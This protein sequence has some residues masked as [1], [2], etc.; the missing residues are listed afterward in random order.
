MVRPPE[1]ILPVWHGC[2]LHLANLIGGATTLWSV[3]VAASFDLARRVMQPGLLL[4]PHTEPGISPIRLADA[5][6]RG[7]S[8]DVLGRYEGERGSVAIGPGMRFAPLDHFVVGLH[9]P[10]PLEGWRRLEE[11]RAAELEKARTAARLHLLLQKWLTTTPWALLLPTVNDALVDRFRLDPDLDDLAVALR[12]LELVHPHPGRPA[13]GPSLQL[14]DGFLR[15][16]RR[17][18]EMLGGVGIEA[19]MDRLLPKKRPSQRGIE[20][21]VARFDRKSED[22]VLQPVFVPSQVRESLP[23]AELAQEVGCA[24]DALAGA[25]LLRVLVAPGRAANSDVQVPWAAEMMLPADVESRVV[26]TLV[27]WTWNALRRWS[28]SPNAAGMVRIVAGG[29]KVLRGAFWDEPL[30][31]R[32]E[33]LLAP[34]TLPRPKRKGRA[35][36]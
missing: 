11:R 23:L 30:K 29:R 5:V 1:I 34:S 4:A 25:D 3:D 35:Q 2:R 13:T 28:S 36:V 17:Y 24:P 12:V 18:R 15:A 7:G 31:S 9:D 21:A 19:A 22:L 8:T 20:A 16:L 27:D 26:A 14:S 33:D 6:V 32:A 10:L